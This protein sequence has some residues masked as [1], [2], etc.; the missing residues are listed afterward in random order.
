MGTA[1]VGCKNKHKAK[2]EL[3]NGNSEHNCQCHLRDENITF[4]GKL[5]QIAATSN[6]GKHSC[7]G[8]CRTGTSQ[9]RE[10]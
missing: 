1:C 10:D 5:D 4:D 6:D 2:G 8:T 9:N 3:I 7:G